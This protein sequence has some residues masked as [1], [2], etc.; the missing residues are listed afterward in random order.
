[1]LSDDLA[2]TWQIFGDFGDYLAKRKGVRKRGATGN[3]WAP[4]GDETA[5]TAYKGTTK[6]SEINDK[7]G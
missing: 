5:Q 7:K 1:M 4:K 6:G 3:K 2:I